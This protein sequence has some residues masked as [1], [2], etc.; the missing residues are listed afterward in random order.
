MPVIWK[1]S[2]VPEIVRERLWGVELVHESVP[3]SVTGASS[4]NVR[5][6][7]NAGGSTIRIVSAPAV[8]AAAVIAPGRSPW[9]HVPELPTLKVSARSASPGPSRAAKTAVQAASPNGTNDG[10]RNMSF[11]LERGASRLRSTPI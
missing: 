7:V 8:A 1:P 10:C 5:G 2:A 3:A 11:L 9:V 4:I 6:P